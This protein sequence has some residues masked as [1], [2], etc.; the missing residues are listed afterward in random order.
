MLKPEQ[1]EAQTF[2]IRIATIRI[3]PLEQ[4]SPAS[5]GIISH[6]GDLRITGYIRRKA[7]KQMRCLNIVFL[8]ASA[9]KQLE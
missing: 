2:R 3:L 7:A 1:I 6:V 8:G 9:S 4:T 5:A